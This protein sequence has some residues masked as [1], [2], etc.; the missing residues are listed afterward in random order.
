MREFIEKIKKVDYRHYINVIITLGFLA[1]GYL[2]VNSIPRLIESMRDL[3][4]SIAYYFC[5]IVMSSNPIV[6]TVVEMPS[7]EIMPSIFEPLTLFPLTWEE[8]Q[9]E[10]TKFSTLFT[11]EE[12]FQ[13]FLTTLGEYL[14]VVARILLLLFTLFVPLMIIARRSTENYNNNYDQDSKPLRVWKWITFHTYYPIKNWLKDYVAF[15]KETP[16]VKIW[17]WMWALYFNLISVIIEFLAFYLYFIVSFAFKDIYAQGLK[18]LYDA[19]PM[20][21][22]VPTFV[23]VCLGV[24]VYEW[25]CREGAYA[26][27]YHNERCNRGFINAL[28]IMTVVWGEMGI[29]KTALITDMALSA[30]VELRDKAFEIMLE[31]DMHFPKFPWVQVRN[32]L[33]NAIEKRVVTDVWTC[34]KWVQNMA[35]SYM[36]Y[37]IAQTDKAMSKSWRRHTLKSPP[38]YGNLIFGYDDTHYP[39][40]YDDKL[41]VIDIWQAIEDYACAYLI[42]SCQCSLIISNYSIRV[43]AIL[44]DIGNFPVWNADFFRRDSRLLDSFSRHSHI[45]DFNMLRLGKRMLDSVQDRSALGFGVYVISEIDKERKNAPNMQE[46]KANADECNQKNDL[47]DS[48]VKMIRHAVV[49]AHR[50]FVRILA[51]LQ[52]PE[53]WSASGR[54][55][56]GVVYIREETDTTPTLPFYSWFWLIEGIFLWTKKKFA[57]FYTEFIYGRGDN[58]LFLW[59]LKGIVARLDNYIERTNNLF[60]SATLR[61]EVESGRMKGEAK[62][63]KYYRMPKKIFSRR[64]RTDCLSAIFQSEEVVHTPIWEFIEYA[65]DVATADELAKQNSHFQTEIRKQREFALKQNT[66]TP[67]ARR[68]ARKNTASEKYAA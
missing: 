55:V 49:I 35:L 34:R 22:F 45:L 47:F 65:N 15:L 28:G 36:A 53:D 25:I 5:G 37:K 50:E 60:G 42:Y 20:V 14:P 9:V 3:G 27:L 11:S 64:Y 13:D 44:Q 10:W 40:T 21:R 12:N 8:F 52:R 33:K 51:D 59:L 57:N 39:T 30:E 56:G 31:S 19:T 43:D 26:R 54:E 23:W 32:E 48:C 38:K 24:V 46:L 68:S 4:I 62:Q 1:L 16:Y 18:L 7:W 17:L 58:T 41:K 63:A 66:A 2:F 6:A 67:P 61:L 29:G